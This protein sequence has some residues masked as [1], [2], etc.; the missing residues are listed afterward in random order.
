MKTKE[1]N[2]F[3]IYIYEEDGFNE[4]TSPIILQIINCHKPDY[5][6]FLNPRSFFIYYKTT[7]NN[8]HKKITSMLADMEKI[9]MGDIRFKNVKVGESTGKM[10]FQ[11]DWLGRIKSSPL[12]GSGNDA[13]RNIVIS[14][15]AQ[16][17]EEPL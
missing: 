3:I 6:E 4:I 16:T 12:G 11:T 13:M 8:S 10:I 5:Y 14:R 17:C 9:I 7:T 1:D 15:H 2:L